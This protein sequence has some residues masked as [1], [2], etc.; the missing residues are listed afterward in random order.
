MS[1]SVILESN[2]IMKVFGGLTFQDGK[3]V[4]TIVATTSKKKGAE[5]VGISLH[6]F[7]DYWGETGNKDELEAALPNPE[8]VLVS[9]SIQ[10]KDFKPLIRGS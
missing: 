10:C 8:I 6:H 9:S 4:R 5:L 2:N 1:A 3:Q 7:R